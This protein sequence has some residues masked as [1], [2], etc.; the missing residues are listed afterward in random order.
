MLGVESVLT[1]VRRL[2]FWQGVAAEQDWRYLLCGVFLVLPRYVS[3]D[4]NLFYV[5]YI[6]S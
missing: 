3:Y 6:S 2:R 4:S 1:T 5:V